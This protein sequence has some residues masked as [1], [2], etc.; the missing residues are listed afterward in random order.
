MTLYGHS[1]SI[2]V[3]VDDASEHGEG[4]ILMTAHPVNYATI[5]IKVYVLLEH[6]VNIGA[7]WVV[8]TGVLLHDRQMPWRL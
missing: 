1:C 6:A 4:D 8:K 7:R 5:L 3:Q 2:A